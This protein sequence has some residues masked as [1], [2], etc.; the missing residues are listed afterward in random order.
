MPEQSKDDPEKRTEVSLELSS[1]QGPLPPPAVV[2]AYKQIIPDGAERIFKQWESETA[3]RH[4]MERGP[5]M[6]PFWDRVLARITALLFAFGCLV[7]IA[8]AISV[9]AQWAAAALS[10]AMI[11]A[12]I[13]AFIR[14]N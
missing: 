14:R 5:Q 6:L 9:G 3:H 13:N 2:E 12:G 4:K 8:Y 11:I 10:G 7:V 1:W